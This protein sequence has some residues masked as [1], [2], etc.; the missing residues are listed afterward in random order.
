M[1]AG[2]VEEL[3]KAVGLAGMGKNK[4]A[5]AM[6]CVMFGCRMLFVSSH[7]AAHEKEKY[8]ERRNRVSSRVSG[9]EK[10]VNKTCGVCKDVPE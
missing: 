2:S 8:C 9:G 10:C 7:L 6:A 3:Y 5:V 4:G 1:P